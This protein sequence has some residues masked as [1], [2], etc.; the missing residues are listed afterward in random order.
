LRS[1]RVEALE[2]RQLLSATADSLRVVSTTPTLE[3]GPVAPIS[4]LDVT[5]SGSLDPASLRA[6]N[7]ALFDTSNP[8]LS[9]IGWHGGVFHDSQVVGGLLYAATDNGLQIF[10]VS[11]PATPVRLGTYGVDRA[12][13]VQVVGSLAYVLC[14]GD[15]QIVDVSDPRAPE[16]VGGYASFPAGATG[17]DVVG[18]LAYVAMN[19]QGVAILDVADPAAPSVLGQYVTA[20]NAYDVQVVG[21]RAYVAA[22]ASGLLILDVSDS[23]APT[24]LGELET[25]GAASALQVVGD[26]AYIAQCDM[27]GSSDFVIVDIADAAAPVLLGGFSFSDTWHPEN[28]QVVGDLAYVAGYEFGLQILNVSNPAA[29]TLVGSC[30]TAGFLSDVEVAGQLA[31]LS[32]NNGGLQV[33]DVSVPATPTRLGGYGT[34]GGANAVEVLGNVAYMADRDGVRIVDVTT[35]EDPRPLSEYATPD[36]AYG[37]DLVGD[38]LYVADSRSGLLIFDISDPAAPV[39]LGS[40][41]TPDV[42]FAVQVVGDL[43]YVADRSAGLQILDVSDPASPILLGG[44]AMLG[45]AMNLHVVGNTAYVADSG[46]GLQLVDV[47]DSAAPVLLGGFRVSHPP[48]WDY[49]HDVQVVGHFAYTVDEWRGLQIIDV[50]DPLAPSLVSTLDTPGMTSGI[51]VVG[52]LAFVADYQNGVRVIDVSDPLTP[53][54][55][56]QYDTP[57]SATQLQVA[58]SL[59]YVADG[60]CGLRVLQ[61]GSPAASVSHV[62]DNTYRFDFGTSLAENHSYA[63][64]LSP[65]FTDAAGHALDQDQDG[66]LGEHHDDAYFV[67]LTTVDNAPSNMAIS[68]ATIAENQPAGTTVGSFSTTDADTPDAFHYQLVAG[69]GAV[70]NASFT[71]DSAGNLH[72]AVAFDYEAQSACSI[73]VRTTDNAGQWFEKQFTVSVADVNEAPTRI[74][75]SAASLPENSALDTVVGTLSASDPDAGDTVI[76]T[77][78]DSAE[79]RFS[80]VNGQIQVAGTLDRETATSHTIRVRATDRAG[81]GLSYEQDLVVTVAN[82]NA[83][84]TGIAISAAVA[85][86]NSPSGTVVGTLSATDPDAGDTFT[87]TLV[88]DAEGRFKIVDGQLQVVGSLDYETAASRTIRVQVTDQN[89]AGL[90]YEQDL[91]IVVANVNEAPTDIALSAAVAAENSPSGTVVGTLS[92]TDPDV[93]DT[94]TYTLVDNAEGRF[95][96]VDG[97]IQVAAPLN[98]E[99]ATGHTIRIRATDQDGVAGEMDLTITV[100]DVHDFDSPGLFNPS[101]STFYLRGENESG[102]ADYTFGYGAPDSGWQTL[103]GDWNGDGAIDVGLFAPESSTF[104]LTDAY[105]SGYAKYTFGY[106]EPNAG[107]IPLVGDWNGDGKSGVGLYDPH[108]S[109]FYLTDNLQGGY[110]EYTFGYGEPAAGWTPLVGDWN[111]DRRT[112][113][114]L[115]NPHASTFYLINALQGGYAEYTFGYGEPSAG[116]QPLVGDWDGDHAA[117][118]GLYDPHGSM[119][120]LTNAFVSGFAQHTFGYGEPNAGWIPL[121]GD[122]NG[123]GQTGVGLFAP[124]SSTFYLT[125]TLTAGYAERTIGFGAPGE[126]WQPIIGCWTTEVTSSAQFSQFPTSLNAQAID[127]LDLAAL[128]ADRL[129]WGG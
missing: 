123:D 7:L 28:V 9:E 54:L 61:I 52:N 60:S 64:W 51:Q 90:G 100:T 26:R 65:R 48:E 40:Y 27:R 84:P 38:R 106:G 128:A 75:L 108:A 85:A 121:V 80:L 78:V 96:L 62:S 59:I 72:A 2:E 95:A 124:S 57:G 70:D 94:F 4:S 6:T 105:V 88:D 33:L 91:V 92:A 73:R 18:G 29:L 83:T 129:A 63:L 24:L 115:F 67:R 20:G 41:D 117:G 71:I 36:T 39:S 11:N 86:E 17:I 13:E 31:Y 34:V 120:Y 97:Q 32:D 23:H 89:G 12:T 25:G 77:L 113:V 55:I 81:A 3:L 1:L 79:G 112:G 19:N 10:D 22:M 8:Q 76:Y 47:T 50:S 99:T 16:R 14:K 109:T 110:A 122:W 93:G 49:L 103:V 35:P 69:S 126:G 37:L 101:A 82:V 21:T 125:N 118:V 127:Q 111:G 116:W 102:A 15:L 45:A 56:A 98:Y 66:L 5:F 107:W 68:E 30:D 74:E 114:G 53:V 46:N 87:Y 104:Y 44:I 58:G 43:A 42:A 119:F